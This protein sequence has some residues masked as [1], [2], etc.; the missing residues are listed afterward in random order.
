MASN[1]KRRNT[2]RG[3]AGAKKQ[4]VIP[5]VETLDEPFEE[6]VEEPVDEVVD[7]VV[8]EPV[9]EPFDE[10]VETESRDEMVKQKKEDKQNLLLLD[11]KSVV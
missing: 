8:D 10:D 7:E 2:N 6:P 4:Q 11:R 1:R 9:D 5:E 3:S